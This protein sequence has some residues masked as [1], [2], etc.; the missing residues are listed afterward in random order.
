MAPQRY[1]EKA[2]RLL[3]FVASVGILC[4][5]AIA[6]VRDHR[7]AVDQV[8]GQWRS[9][10]ADPYM[11]A[12]RLLPILMMPFFFASFSVL[13]MLMPRYVPFWLDEPFARMDQFLFFGYHPWELTHAVFTTAEATVTFDLLYSI[14]VPLLSVAIAGFA[15]F[16]P[17]AERARFFLAFGAAWFFL[18]FIGAWLGASAGPCFLAGLNSPLAPE[19]AGLMTRL[20][21]ASNSHDMIAQAVEWQQMLWEGYATQTYRFGMG[22]SA[23]PSLHNA[24]AV[25]YV[26]LGFRFGR[27]AGLIA[28]TYAVIIFV[29]SVHLGWHYAVDG[30]FA[31]IGMWLIWLGVNWWCAKSG[32]DSRLAGMLIEKKLSMTEF[33][34]MEKAD[35]LSSASTWW[36]RLTELMQ[37]PWALP[38]LVIASTAFFH[39]ILTWD[40]DGQTSA[41]NQALRHF[42]I[43][44]VWAEIIVLFLAMR[45]GWRP[46]EQFDALSRHVKWL[47]LLL[48]ASMLSSSMF[49]SVSPATSLFF[50]VRMI[51]HGLVLGCLIHLVA[52]DGRFRLGEWTTQLSVGIV[53][54]VGAL[55]LFCL[56]VPTPQEFRWHDRIP[57]ATNIRQI[58]TVLGVMALIPA[59]KLLFARTRQELLSGWML[60]TAILC[61]IMWSGSRGPLLGFVAAV[62]IAWF[63]TKGN[64]S[65]NRLA[66]LSMSTLAAA[67]LSLQ[68]PVPHPMFGLLRMTRTI[69][70]ADASSGRWAV[71]EAT[72]DAIRQSPML[73]YGSGTYRTNM[74]QLTGNPFNHPHNFVLQ[75]VYDWG[76]IAA[77]SALVLLGCL[78][79]GILHNR[80][81][82]AEMQFLALGAFVGVLAMGSIDGALFYPLPMLI[83]VACIAP[84]LVPKPHLRQT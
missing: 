84:C 40:W 37:R 62:V 82:P 55:V 69:D 16:A 31:A 13:K 47:C 22:I 41:I 14:W 66:M 38:V 21:A 80:D 28:A 83:A 25:L 71:W 20:H 5:F 36:I 8:I 53:L 50:S 72:V 60:L 30:I 81:K 1:G 24:I 57:S 67:V 56:A 45:K 77:T 49:M 10:L 76:F 44:I 42:S 27:I 15:L 64:V 26:F 46:L 4:Q 52:H 75:Y 35:A 7:T 59:A 68:L 63:L 39:A 43:T 6:I 19:F 32:Y 3:P 29:G 23:M 11:V 48:C 70:A 34:A 51:L 2:L 78:G 61:V 9:A 33:T 12:A 79:L 54:Y 58:G 17:R 73:G 18:G 65:F 74:E